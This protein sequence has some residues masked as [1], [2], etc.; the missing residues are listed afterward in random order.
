[1]MDQS[2]A[3]VKRINPFFIHRQSDVSDDP[4][5]DGMSMIRR[6]VKDGD[7]IFRAR[8]KKAKKKKITHR[9]QCTKRAASAGAHLRDFMHATSMHGLKYAA[10]KE[11]SWIER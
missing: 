1:M 10:E 5:M 8:F 4:W 6:K 3:A 2:S 11:A 7:K 9:F